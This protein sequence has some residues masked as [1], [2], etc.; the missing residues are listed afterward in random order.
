MCVRVFVSVCMYACVR[1]CVSVWPWV[2]VY[3]F[4]CACACVCVLVS[5]VCARAYV[6]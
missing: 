5:Y 3:V 2:R 4:A 6:T 1:A